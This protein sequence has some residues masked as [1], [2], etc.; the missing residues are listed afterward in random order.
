[1]FLQKCV[2]Q[3][4]ENYTD[5]EKKRKNVTV[6]VKWWQFLFLGKCAFKIFL[7]SKQLSFFCCFVE[8]VLPLPRSSSFLVHS[9]L[10]LSHAEPVVSLINKRSRFACARFI[11]GVMI[12]YF[13]GN[14]PPLNIQCHRL[15]IPLRRC[16]PNHLRFSVKRTVGSSP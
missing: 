13:Y 14:S 7:N 4:R 10:P 8:P 5:L 6:R 16:P 15:R 12:H 3:N 2:T 1:M 11:R 9:F